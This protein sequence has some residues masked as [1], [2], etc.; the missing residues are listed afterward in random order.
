ML[1]IEY[2]VDICD[3]NVPPIP[4]SAFFKYLVKSVN[5]LFSEL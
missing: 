3:A 2:Q 4:I 5:V 1:D